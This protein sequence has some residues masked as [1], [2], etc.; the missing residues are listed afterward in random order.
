M[1]GGGALAKKTK[2]CYSNDMTTVRRLRGFTLI[3]LLIA[4]AIA[5]TLMSLAIPS[6]RTFAARQER[7]QAA[8]TLATDFRFAQS[9][10]LGGVKIPSNCTPATPLIGW[11]VRFVQGDSSYTIV[12]RCQGVSEQIVRTVLLPIGIVISSVSGSNPS[13]TEVLFQPI[14]KSVL[15]VS[16]AESGPPFSIVATDEIVITLTTPK[17][18]G[19]ARVR[20]RGTGDVYDEEF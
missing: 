15:F 19:G 12:A 1:R 7:N 13:D 2:P 4:I 14:K 16:N 6:Y 8:K 3:E 11:Y 5:A 20:V 17:A 18:S 10:A 9:Q